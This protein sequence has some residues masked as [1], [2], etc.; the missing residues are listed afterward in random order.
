MAHYS[1]GML[2]HTLV[3]PG[4]QLGATWICSAPSSP[5]ELLSEK[6]WTS[7]APAWGP[8][9]PLQVPP[10]APTCNMTSGGGLN[11]LCGWELAFRF[12]GS[13]PCLV[14]S[15]AW[16]GHGSQGRTARAQ[17]AHPP[18]ARAPSVR[19]RTSP[20]WPGHRCKPSESRTMP[21]DADDEPRHRQSYFWYFKVVHPLSSSAPGHCTIW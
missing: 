20:A 7:A 2:I 13:L 12:L 10:V 5:F 21:I 8:A 4:E 14:S 17:I 6:Q 11:L 15:G 16:C 18:E 19:K 3:T 1:D 9:L